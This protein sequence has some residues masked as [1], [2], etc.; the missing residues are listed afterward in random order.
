MTLTATLDATLAALS[1]P[2]R[3]AII[4]RLARGPAYVNELAK[5]FKISQQAISKHLSYLERAKL[6]EKRREGRRHFCAL[7]ALPMKEVS[8]WVEHYR[9]LWEERFDRLDAYLKELQ[10]K[11]KDNGR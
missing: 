11:E 2:T 9:K 7:K 3:R 10:V 6:I 1:D 4:D 8:D 5:P